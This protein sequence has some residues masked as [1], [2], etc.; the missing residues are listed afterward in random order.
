M[1]D[2]RWQMAATF[3]IIITGAIISSYALYATE[4]T[5]N[6][7]RV[8]FAFGLALIVLGIVSIEQHYKHFKYPA[9]FL[10]L[11]NASYSIYLIHN[12]LLSITQRVLDKIPFMNWQLGMLLGIGFSIMAGLLYYAL[13]EKPAIQLARKLLPRS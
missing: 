13:V 4:I 8:L 1:A 3:P 11:G 9:I 7:E 2:G 10:L 5:G 6:E 12:P